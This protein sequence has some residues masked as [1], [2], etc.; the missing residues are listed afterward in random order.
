MVF[1]GFDLNPADGSVSL[2][3][4]KEGFTYYKPNANDKEIDDIFTKYDKNA[5]GKL[6]V[7]EFAKGLDDLEKKENEKKN[8]KT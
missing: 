8:P 1:R 3:E 5:D 4:L 7:Q 2:S 6:D